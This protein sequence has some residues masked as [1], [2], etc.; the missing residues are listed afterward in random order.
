VIA[1][2]VASVDAVI[3][4][5]S[6]QNRFARRVN[7]EV[8]SHTAMMDPI[9]PELRAAL[10]D[11][12][13]GIPTIPFF[14]TVTGDATAPL[15]D[16]EYWLANVRQPARLSQ[17]ITAAAQD[18]AT[19]IEISA[20]PILTHAVND[21]LE[22]VTHHHS[23]GTLSRDGDDTVSFHTNLNTIHTSN[24]PQTPHPPEPHPV[25]PTTPWHHTRHW[26]PAGTVRRS[27]TPAQFSAD[28]PP[29]PAEWYCELAWPP[30]RL[31]GAPATVDSGWLVVADSELGTEIGRIL[32]DD[33]R[34]MVL[35]PS[36]L[37]DDAD[38]AALADALAGVTHV[39]FAPEMSSGHFDAEP[40]HGVFNAARR[41]TASVAAVAL[42]PRLFLLTRN[43]QPVGEGDRANPAHA[44]LWGLGRTLALE[45]PEIW[46]AII[47][48]DESVP[49]GLAARYVLD[50]AH[51]RDGEDQVVYRAGIRRV[52]RLQRA[53]PSSTSPAEFDKDRSHLVIGA[54]GNVG[55]HLIRRLADMGAATIVAVSR[56][57][58]SRLD[59]L[60]SSLSATGT[61]LVTVAADAADETAMSALFDRFGTDLP[62]LAGIYLA[63]FGGGPITLR[64]MTDDD[65]IA[66]FR[67]KLDVVSVLHNLS[68]NHPLRQ[69]VLFSSISGVTGSRWLAHYA[70]TTTFL[71]TFA[72][73]R[74]A[75]GLPATAIN[76]GLWKSLSDTQTG[77]QRQVTLDSGLEPMPDE[78]AIQA[79]PSV[80]G[81]DAPVRSTIVAADW[82]RLA[83]AYRT[84]AALHIVDDMLPTDADSDTSSMLR[85]EF[86]QALRDCEPTRRRELLVD[87]VTAQ[88]V[89]AMGL[90]SPHLLD[91]SVGF[92][93]SG[94]D[95][96]MSVTLQR[97][98][99]ESL[100]EVLPAAVVFDY[101]TVEA[102][103]D[104]LA[105]ILPELAEV[106]DQESVDAYDDLTDDELLQQLSDR[107]G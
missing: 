36:M 61:T 66:M 19:F 55:P 14:S 99:A 21:T 4:A 80:I 41:L 94:M 90:A 15:L 23:V 96:L 103:A 105:T 84:R 87:H 76:W 16:A 64:D 72:Y 89:A 79:L 29:I 69:F 65:V 50:E 77:Q 60:A 44:V 5:V 102:L 12:N 93:Q 75:A 49:V 68:L 22:S 101:P 92:F 63:A 70:A 28:S 78:I 57:P 33:S 10:A 85:T 67:P 45:H 40:G 100:G 95:S 98:L 106:A 18:H 51:D 53:Y 30:R 1:G 97:S 31:S 47:D 7:M 88:V 48:V 73:A 59:E 37:A 43:A 42:P 82:S 58:G 20:N 74:R 11:L 83:T 91:P 3:A 34:V 39:L 25:L 81:Q 2:P 9:L 13:A 62:P 38:K 27:V 71:D 46:G 54:T 24:P 17:A 26:L 6:A 52:P 32:G 107:L 104:Y 35:P 8:A 86:R 56:N